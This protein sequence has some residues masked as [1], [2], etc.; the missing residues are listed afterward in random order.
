MSRIIVHEN[1]E[2]K[3]PVLIVA[4]AGWNDAGR[5][6]TIAVEHLVGTWSASKFAEI[7]PDEFY[8]FTTVRPW[9]NL[10][11]D[12]QSNVTWPGSHLYAYRDPN[13]ELDAILLLGPEPALRWRT[14]TQEIVD[15]AKTYQVSMVVTLGAYLAEISHHDRVPISGWAWPKALHERLKVVEV[16]TVTYEGP[17]GILT[18]LASALAEASVP[19]AS[20][21]AAVPGYLGP[22]PNP[23]A[24]LALATCLERAFGMNLKLEDLAKSSDQFERKVTD[25]LQ[26]VHALPGLA[27][28]QAQAGDIQ[29]SPTETNTAASPEGVA[30]D[31]P[32]LPPAEEVIRNVEELLRQNRDS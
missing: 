3:R 14:F 32:E 8:D 12:G 31:L 23:K 1:P 28:Y 7:N 21:W 4:F 16:A 26:R 13:G 30:P 9:A 10:G 6:A 24:A 29:G 20:L 5:S 25:A 19:V 27:M 2:L 22:T 11:A 17:T 18:V 15:L